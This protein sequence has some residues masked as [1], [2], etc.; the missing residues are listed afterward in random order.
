MKETATKAPGEE[1]ESKQNSEDDKEEDIS[2]KTPGERFELLTKE[3]K[4][5]VVDNTMDRVIPEQQ[6]NFKFNYHNHEESFKPKDYEI[7]ENE[8]LSTE[9]TTY[10]MSDY[11]SWYPKQPYKTIEYNPPILREKFQLSIWK[12]DAYGVYKI[13]DRYF[14]PKN[15]RANSEDFRGFTLKVSL[16]SKSIYLVEETSSSTKEDLLVLIIDNATLEI[17]KELIVKIRDP[18][19]NSEGYDDYYD[20]YYDDSYSK[21][22]TSSSIGRINVTNNG[23]KVIVGVTK[24]YKKVHYY[25]AIYNTETGE[26]ENKIQRTQDNKLENKMISCMKQNPDKPD[27]II[28]GTYKGETIEFQSFNMTN[29]NCTLINSNDK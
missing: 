13:K 11:V 25:Y 24:E 23:K 12:S 4:Q 29:G 2:N 16:D 8:K 10:A 22:G 26:I 5:K 9:N 27:E 7:P 18:E 17:T 20:S 14:T 3:E 21:F 6:N 15:E 19:F 1:D 28:I